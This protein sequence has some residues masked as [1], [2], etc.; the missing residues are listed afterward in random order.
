MA[1]MNLDFDVV[2][3]GTNVLEV[4]VDPRL[5]TRVDTGID[6]FN[7]CLSADARVKGLLPGGVYLFTGTPGAGKTTLALQLADS[8]CAQGH[9]ALFN[10]GE[11][12]PAQVKMTVERLRLKHGFTLGSD[13]FVDRP[14]SQAAAKRV[15]QTLREHMEFLRVPHDK[16]NARR[17]EANRKHMV[18]IVD[19]LQCMN[20]GKW[21][22]DSNTK[23]PIRVLEEL[24]QYAKKHYATMIVIGQVGKS[25]Q[26]KGNN[27]LLHMV[28][29]H[30]HLYVDEDEKSPTHGKRILEC[31]KNRFGPSGISLPLEIGPR[32]LE[33]FTSRG[34]RQTRGKKV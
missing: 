7:F 6:F 25:G 32:G 8:L 16:A 17:S 27:T 24:T 13:I 21:G 3:K 15:K 33:E 19:S 18:V 34:N 20:D 4:E 31:R 22:F 23:T 5:R 2:E 1:S 10:T 28:D 14:E 30:L 12:S 29:G 26:F 9:T 11:E